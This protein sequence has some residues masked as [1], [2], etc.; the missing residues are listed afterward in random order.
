MLAAV[1]TADQQ[2]WACRW[3]MGSAHRYMLVPATAGMYLECA[4]V[5]GTRPA[6]G[7]RT[8]PTAA[9]PICWCLSLCGPSTYL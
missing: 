8:A 3:S 2:Q 5:L 4:C 1:T 7:G 9:V 6:V